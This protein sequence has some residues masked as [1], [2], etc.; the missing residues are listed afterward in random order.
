ME[1]ALADAKLDK[2]KINEIIMVGGS[3]R[4]DK[5]RKIV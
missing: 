4:I 1:V 2:T 5:V 3:T